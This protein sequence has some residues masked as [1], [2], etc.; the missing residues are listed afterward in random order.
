MLDIFKKIETLGVMP[1]LTIKD[2]IDA[3]PVGQAISDGGISMVEVTFRTEAAEDSIRLMSKAL[4][5]LLIGAGTVL[6][7]NQVDQAMEAG[8]KFIVT[9]GISREVVEYCLEN[10]IPIIPGIAT[11]TDIE[12][13]IRYGIKL[14]KFFPAEANGGIEA[15]K[16]MSAPYPNIKFMPT[17]GINEQNLDDY[18]HFDKVLA[19]SG[20]WMS[21]PEMIENNDLELIQETSKKSVFSMLGF[22]LDYIGLNFNKD[23][24]ALTAAEDWTKYFDVSITDAPDGFFA[25]KRFEAVKPGGYGLHGHIAIST[26]HIGRAIAYLEKRGANFDKDRAQYDTNGNM[27][28]IYME[29]QIGGMAIKLTQR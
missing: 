15:L 21:T 19:V 14:V 12:K 3:I 26:Y 2:A 1:E 16:A 7:V 22:K 17:G 25:G 5:D 18:L 20:N 28:Q 23:E 24:E 9:P 27:T 6:S 13:A 4:P 8:A 10:E 29:Q 11:P